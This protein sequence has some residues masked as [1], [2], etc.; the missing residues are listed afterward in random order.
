MKFRL[1]HLHSIA[2][3]TAAFSAATGAGCIVAFVSGPLARAYLL[4]AAE[5]A[6]AI[7]VA[8]L[9]V[10]VLAS[11]FLTWRRAAIDLAQSGA[12]VTGGS[13]GAQ[14]AIDAVACLP[15]RREVLYERLQIDEP[16]LCS[17]FLVRCTCWSFCVRSEDRRAVAEGTSLVAEE[18]IRARN[19]LLKVTGLPLVH[20]Y[21]MD[22]CPYRFASPWRRVSDR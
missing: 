8:S 17:Q 10:S 19:L 9:L 20:R 3:W 22:N 14:A 12:A 1:S 6:A 5:V 2:I 21:G 4:I 18:L 16:K 7:G 11:C 13:P 15:K